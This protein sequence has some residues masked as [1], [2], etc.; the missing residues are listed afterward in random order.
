M[1]T[2][3]KKTA[4][5]FVMLLLTQFS[6]GQNTKKFFNDLLSNAQQQLT[7]SQNNSVNFTNIDAVS[8]LKEMLQTGTKNAS[9]QLSTVNGYF[10]NSFVKIM[11]PPEAAKV[12]ATVRALGFGNVAD[13]TI[14][15]MNRAAEDAAS[16]VTPI[17]INAIKNMSIQDGI[18]IVKGG[19]NSATNFLKTKTTAELTTTFR[20]V[21]EKSLNQY[22]AANYWNQLFNIYNKLPT[23][24]NPINPDLTS[25]VTEKA[26]NG[27]F[28]TISQEENKIRTDP[29][30][31]TT[32]LLQKVFGSK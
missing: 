31:R 2:V 3:A 4:V 11:M 26:L 8:A 15:Y 19:N 16:K 22:N 14:L 6:N 17:F 30:A 1:K 23:V 21:I 25:Y 28:L 24:K 29:A 27:L 12:E 7:Q 10:A 20:P 13:K 32:T 18:A 5:L 9:G